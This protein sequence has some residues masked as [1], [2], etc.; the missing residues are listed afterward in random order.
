M[1]YDVE[2][3]MIWYDMIWYNMTWHGMTRHDTIWYTPKISLA[4]LDADI[5]DSENAVQFKMGDALKPHGAQINIYTIWCIKY[6]N[7]FHE[8]GKI[9]TEMFSNVLSSWG[10]H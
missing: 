9:S 6:S 2:Y 3:D 7:I 5:V 8:I 10:T 4:T 1:T